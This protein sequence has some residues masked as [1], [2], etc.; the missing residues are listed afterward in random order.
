MT[1]LWWLIYAMSCFRLAPRHIQHENTTKLQFV[2]VSP[3]RLA[4][5]K[6]ENT[7]DKGENTP[8]KMCR[9]FASYLSC[10]RVFASAGRKVETTKLRQTWTLSCCCV[11]YLSSFRPAD[12]KTRKYDTLTFSTFRPT[13]FRPFAPPCFDLSPRRFLPFVLSPRQC[14]N[15]KIRHIDFFRL[16]D[17]SPFRPPIHI[18]HNIIQTKWRVFMIVSFTFSLTF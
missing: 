10:L 14:E 4:G 11:F 5:R 16:F 7:T 12:A 15:T 1:G 8:H 2:V 17:L 13:V 9:V 3:F 6:S 18:C